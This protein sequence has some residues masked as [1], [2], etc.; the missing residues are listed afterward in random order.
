M[1]HAVL[2]THPQLIPP[3]LL[4]TVAGCLVCDSEA[5]TKTSNAEREKE[6]RLDTVSRL[7]RTLLMVLDQY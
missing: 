4:Q 3:E 1:K 5:A 7:L 2:P 6:E